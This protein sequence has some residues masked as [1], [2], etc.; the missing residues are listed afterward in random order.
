MSGLRPTHHNELPIPL[1]VSGSGGRG[2]LSQ[3]APP[4]KQFIK[5]SCYSSFFT[6]Q[7]RLPRRQRCKGGFRTNICTD[8]E[9]KPPKQFIK[10][11]CYSSFF[12]S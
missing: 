12:T 7:S 3:E 4:P 10:E 2:V 5:E 9:N 1:S 6:R 8:S 11:S